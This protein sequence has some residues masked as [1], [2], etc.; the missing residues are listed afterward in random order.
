MET[1]VL[2]TALL[3][4]PAGPSVVSAE[5]ASPVPVCASAGPEY[6]AFE[7]FTTR[8]V[9]GTGLAEA[10]AELEVSGGSPFSITLGPDGSYVYDVSVSLDRMKAPRTG[11][12]VA[13]ATT[14]D[15]DQVERLGTLDEQLRTSGQ[16]RWNK[17][18]VVVTWESEDDP[19]ATMWKGPVAFRGMSRSGMMHTM[20][21]HGALQ[22]EN[23]AA[24]GYGN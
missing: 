10:R 3:G 20:V 19:E 6:Y 15:I 5:A 7:L 8:N 24:Y 4:A 23:C 13:W 18:L 9:P 21:G 12:L 2:L 14:P 17:F 1:I 16:V 11:H 22:Q